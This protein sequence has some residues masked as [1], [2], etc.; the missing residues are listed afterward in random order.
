M[1]PEKMYQKPYDEIP[2]GILRAVVAIV[3]GDWVRAG[4]ART[5]IQDRIFRLRD[6]QERIDGA[7]EEF[8][9][10]P[11]IFRVKS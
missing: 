8:C 9:K 3:D 1:K 6:E 4:L 2:R 5:A 10:D 11:A 7:F